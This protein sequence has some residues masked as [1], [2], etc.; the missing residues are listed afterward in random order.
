MS[1]VL[2]LLKPEIHVIGIN[3][4]KI[5][6]NDTNNTTNINL[7]GYHPFVFDPTET[8]DGGTGL[9]IKDSLVFKRRDDLKFNSSSSHESTF[10]EILY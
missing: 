2:T 9:F 4:H 1:T 3:E 10:I 7:E 6:K 5:H 8:S